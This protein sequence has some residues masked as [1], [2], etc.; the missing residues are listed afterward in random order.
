MAIPIRRARVV[1]ALALTIATFWPTSALTRVDL[2]ALGAPITAT[3]SGAGFVVR[4]H[5][6]FPTAQAAFVSASCLLAP[7][8]L[9]SPRPRLRHANREARR[10][11][12]CRSGARPDKPGWTGY[13]SRASSWSADLGCF[14]RRAVP[15]SAAPR[16]AG[17]ALRLL[18]ARL[19][20]RSPR[21][22]PRRRR[23]RRCRPCWR[24]HRAP[25]CRGGMIAEVQ[26]RARS[27]R[28]SRDRRAVLKRCDSLPSG[29]S[30]KRS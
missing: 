27:R 1:C 11:V 24:R 3:K 23:R 26:A 13:A 20:D 19:P 30:G 15:R 12:R 21:S 2:P 6:S 18:R 29:S 4:H 22:A 16:F 8:S 28:R 14:G 9:A 7:L 25:A 5:C 17:S 10:V